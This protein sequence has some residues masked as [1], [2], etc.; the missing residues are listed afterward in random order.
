M[1]QM[2]GIYKQPRDR[3]DTSLQN[4]D[5][6]SS[7]WILCA[8]DLHGIGTPTLVCRARC[9]N[10]KSSRLPYAIKALQHSETFF[11]SDLKQD[12]KSSAPEVG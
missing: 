12:R 3:E 11:C 1:P 8:F 4:T 9:K 10:L 5:P 2:D 6:A 7:L